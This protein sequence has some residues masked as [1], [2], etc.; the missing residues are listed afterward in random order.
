VAVAVVALSPVALAAMAQQDPTGVQTTTTTTADEAPAEDSTSTTSPDVPESSTTT[1]D[2]GAPGT[3]PTSSAPTTT[4]SRPPASPDEPGTTEVPPE[5][6]RSDEDADEPV[7]TR[8]AVSA[9]VQDSDIP[10]G[11]VLIALGVLAAVVIGVLTR[12]RR[13]PGDLA[14]GAAGPPLHVEE[15]DRP[16]AAPAGAGGLSA[17]DP[18]TLEFLVELGGALLDAGGAVSHGIHDLGVLVLPSTLVLSLR[19]GGSVVTEVRASTAVPLRLDQVDDV[20]RLVRDAEDGSLTAAEGRRQLDRIRTSPRR[21]G[22][23]LLV[24]Y[25]VS[26]IGLAM[27]LRGDWVEVVAAGV[28]GSVVGALRLVTASPQKAAYQAFWPL[29]AAATASASAFALGR[30]VDGLAVFPVVVAPLVTFL[31]GALL[32][33]GVLELSTGQVVSGASRL[34]AGMMRL[35]LLAL[36]ILAGARLV[37]V[38]GGAIRSG[39]GGVVA[40]VSPWIGVALF[41]VG[42]SWFNGARRSAQSWILVVL[43]VAYAGQVL[44]GLFFGS[45]LSAFFGAVAMTPVAVLASRRPSGPTPLVTFLPAFWLLVPGALGLQGVSLIV[46]DGLGGVEALVTTLISMVGISFG[47]LLG[48]VIAGVD[49]SRPWSL[50]PERQ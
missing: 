12:V 33:I 22:S 25:S 46:G 19:R 16:A 40:A 24:A 43:Y 2:G 20:L 9:S 34:A 35:V 10:L 42:F 13:Q 27:V 50:P 37:G 30:L 45:S 11:S 39:A 41:G 44:G 29:V 31:P 6:G 7:V 21:R 47:L 15:A 36:G 32:T 4:A 48:L 38:D 26:T 1:A 28:L 17:G 23:H 14:S 49:P 18:K 8:P 5:G 3:E